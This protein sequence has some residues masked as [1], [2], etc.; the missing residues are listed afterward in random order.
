MDTPLSQALEAEGA[1]VV[2]GT[3]ETPMAEVLRL[4]V[5]DDVSLKLIQH[6]YC[7]PLPPAVPESRDYARLAEAAHALLRAF[8]AKLSQTV[9][10]HFA[11]E[12]SPIASQVAITQ[13]EPFEVSP[14]AEV[15]TVGTGFFSAR[16]ALVINADHPAVHELV[17]LAATE[18]A[19]ASYL[20]AK[21][22]FV[23]TSLDADTD[24]RLAQL[25]MEA[26]WPS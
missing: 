12:G 5:P 10:G 17:R 13:D 15:R 25:A 22:F 18:P 7:R 9:L 21:L 14:L 19:V 4:V 1:T 2:R 24:G 3:L 23:G 6:A 8:G 16:R 26:R 11:Y 20:L